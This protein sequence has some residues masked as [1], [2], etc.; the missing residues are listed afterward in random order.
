MNPPS[1]G[2]SSVCFPTKSQASASFAGVEASEA[3]A[4]EAQ[5]PCRG[6]G[7]RC[8]LAAG[9]SVGGG[10]AGGSSSRV[11][12]GG[13]RDCISSSAAGVA[14]ALLSHS[15]KVALVV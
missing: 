2:L 6:E 9:V 10:G 5:D 4:S 11:C 1:P 3:H 12:E 15:C 14:G 13:G 7:G 8:E